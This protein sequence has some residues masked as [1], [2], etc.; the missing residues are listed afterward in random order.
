MRGFTDKALV[1]LSKQ[2]G[3]EECGS[4]YKYDYKVAVKTSST[5]YP[6]WEFPMTVLLRTD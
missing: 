2:E 4:I 1:L 6:V 3:F 5:T